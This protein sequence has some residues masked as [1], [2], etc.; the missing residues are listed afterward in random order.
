[1]QDLLASLKSVEHR[2]E[3]A[4]RRL[5]GLQEEGSSAARISE[6]PESDQG[7]RQLQSSQQITGTL[8]SGTLTERVHTIQRKLEALQPQ[9]IQTFHQQ[10]TQWT[11]T[12]K[13]SAYLRSVPI[14][15]LVPQSMQ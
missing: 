12:G 11:R 5:W 8:S 9:E 3:R 13:P 4:E 1:M 2:V 10:G 15:L 6:R 7:Q 14:T